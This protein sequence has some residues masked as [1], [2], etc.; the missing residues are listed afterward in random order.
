MTTP[1]AWRFPEDAD[2]ADPFE[3]REFY[4]LCYAYRCTSPADPAGVIVN[5]EAV[6]D[7][8]RKC[9]S[10]GDARELA[11]AKRLDVIRNALKVPDGESVES[12]AA[13]T[14]KTLGVVVERGARNA[15]Y[16]RRLQDA[17]RDLLPVAEET[18]KRWPNDDCYLIPTA[19]ARD[20]LLLHIVRDL[21]APLPPGTIVDGADYAR[22]GLSQCM[23]EKHCQWM[24]WCRI[25]SMCWL[26]T[27]TPSSGASR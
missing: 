25:N 15:E 16:A 24:P 18:C 22:T 20:A 10:D 2:V 8:G 1:G 14:M 6:K 19:R 23:T 12:C 4:E 27:S 17:L 11:Y 21:P 26:A 5:F 9:L 13:R 7:F 3:T